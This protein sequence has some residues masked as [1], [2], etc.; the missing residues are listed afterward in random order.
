MYTY[1]RR[2]L[3]LAKTSI[4]AISRDAFRGLVEIP[5]ALA[6]ATLEALE[7]GQ[8]KLTRSQVMHITGH[9]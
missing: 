4:S 7:N 8:P 6:E 3:E 5:L 2:N 9:V 1:A